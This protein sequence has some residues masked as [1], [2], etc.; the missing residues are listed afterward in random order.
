M[1]AHDLRAL[2]TSMDGETEGGET[3]SPAVG[4]LLPALVK[5][6][7]CVENWMLGQLLS[8]EC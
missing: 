3:S 2:F 6:P 4:S 5:P 7:R 8:K 1:F